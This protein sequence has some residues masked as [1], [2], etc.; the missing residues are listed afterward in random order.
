MIVID[1]SA[2]IAAIMQDE[3]GIIAQNICESIIESSNVAIVPP[4]FYYETAQVLLKSLRR[5]RI[6]KMEYKKHLKLLLEFPLLVDEDIPIFEIALIAEE[7][8]LSFYDAA[9]L[10]SAKRNG[11]SLATLDKQLI[12]A[13]LKANV[14]L[15]LN[16]V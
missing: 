4:L 10:E 11:Y 2:F 12:V 1:A 3:G 5:N 13:A 15:V 16:H 7:Y 9:Y 14:K 6:D 8:G